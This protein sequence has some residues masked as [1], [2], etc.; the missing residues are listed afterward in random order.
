MILFTA[1]L[2]ADEPIPSSVSLGYPCQTTSQCK[3][4]DP[5][6]VCVDGVCACRA[7]TDERTRGGSLFRG[8]RDRRKVIKAFYD[9]DQVKTWNGSQSF[10][11]VNY[12]IRA[13]Q[14]ILPSSHADAKVVSRGGEAAR[15]LSRNEKWFCNARDPRLCPKG[16]FQ[17]SMQCERA[18]Q[19]LFL[20]VRP[21]VADI[22]SICCRSE[23]RPL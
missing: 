12:S 4:S 5:G 19:A 14:V 16:T 17:A 20:S 15:R 22:F 21:T 3:T 1:S 6:S 10:A 2:N 13:L 18:R 9:G 11:F 7:R 23:E 8:D